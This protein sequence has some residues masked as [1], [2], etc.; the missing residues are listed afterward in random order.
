MSTPSADPVA[1]PPARPPQGGSR[2]R[3]RLLIASIVLNVFLI[4]AIGA[5]VAARHGL[6]FDGDRGRPPRAFDLPSPRKIR[7]VLPED[8]RPVAE[9]MF[10]AHRDEMRGRIRALFEARR[11]VA[12]AMRA[13]PFDRVALDAAF[14]EL[15]TRQ[16]DVATAAQG[17]IADLAAELDAESRGRIAELL[18]VRRESDQPR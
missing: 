1:P 14:A 8:S 18:D 4:G 16:D 6:I 3:R 11:Q 17:I 7:A 13:E 15:R 12:A 2:T 10:A 5:G 9:A